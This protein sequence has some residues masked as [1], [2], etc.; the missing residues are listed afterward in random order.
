M[1]PD[2]LLEVPPSIDFPGKGHFKPRC[3]RVI[4][5]VCVWRRC[6]D[7]IGPAI[8]NCLAGSGI[9]LTDFRLRAVRKTLPHL[10]IRR[11]QGSFAGEC[12][13]WIF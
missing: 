7:E 3:I 1:L 4:E 6:D 5:I 8:G 9:V 11:K 12:R 13:E 10:H 2:T